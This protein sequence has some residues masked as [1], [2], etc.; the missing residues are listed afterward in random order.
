[1]SKIHLFIEGPQYV[2]DFLVKAGRGAVVYRRMPIYW[3]NPGIF[4]W[5]PGFEGVPVVW[6]RSVDLG[7]EFSFPDLLQA[8][9]CTKTYKAKTAIG[10]DSLHP[11]HFG[12]LSDRSLTASLMP[13][14]AMIFCGMVPWQIDVLLISLFPKSEGGT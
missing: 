14:R 5:N 8:R 6:P 1:M 9:R 12:L 11:R 2:P 10:V 7:P 4:F 13:I 3:L